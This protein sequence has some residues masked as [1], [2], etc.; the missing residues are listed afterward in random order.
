M[1][2]YDYIIIGAGASGLLLAD[3]LGTDDFF[4]EKSILVLDKDTKQKNDRTWCFWEVG[5]GPFK[6]ILHKKWPN[7][8][9]ASAQVDLQQSI[10][11]YH[12]KMLRGQDFY[13]QYLKKIESHPNCT[14]K[15]DTI[16]QVTESGRTVSVKGQEQTYLGNFIFDSRFEYAKLGLQQKYPVLQQHFLGW[17]IKTDQSV[18]SCETATFMDFSIPQK[19]NTRFMYVLPFSEKEAL[20]EYTLF[21]ENTLEKQEYENA[22]KAYLQEL[23]IQQ[24]EILEVEQGNI[25]MTCFDFTQE[26]SDRILKIG[27]SGGWAKASTG[28]TFYS[29]AKKVTKLVAHLK[30][31]KPL[32]RFQKKN[33]YW[34]YDL[35]FLDVLYRHNELG[36]LIFESLF[37]KRSP[38]LVLKFLDEETTLWEDIQVMWACPK[39]PFF[40]ALLRRLF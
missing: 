2:T 1:P 11:P 39:K 20:V 3:A 6:P 28:Y 30:A 15:N 32:S 10:N 33:R 35:L 13:Q 25:P 34:Y 7:I 29:S 31:H 17:F 22:I 4:R 9:F 27:I 5:D 26:N 12:Y 40:N 36:N 19:N 24:Y 37:K 21:S 16:I 14:F 8:Q 18:F 23:G 38:Q